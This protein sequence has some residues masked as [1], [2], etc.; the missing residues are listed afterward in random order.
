MMYKKMAALTFNRVDHA[1]IHPSFA[2][3]LCVSRYNFDAINF[4]NFYFGI[5]G[6]FD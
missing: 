2:L 6:G 1:P 5:V 4:G 3:S